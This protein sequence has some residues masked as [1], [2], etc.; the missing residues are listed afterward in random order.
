M[1]AAL[2]LCM[3]GW[4]ITRM[5]GA[6]SVLVWQASCV[7]GAWM[8]LFAAAMFL[9]V[10]AEGDREDSVVAAWLVRAG[11]VQCVLAWG[12]GINDWLRGPPGEAPAWNTDLGG[13][14]VL[15]S[16]VFPFVT[17]LVLLSWLGRTAR[18]LRV[19]IERPA[20]PN[21]VQVSV[22]PFRGI[23]RG[24]ARTAEARFPW[25]P[26]FVAAFG[27]AAAFESPAPAYWML[28]AWAPLLAALT[29]R[30]ARAFWPSIATLPW[31]AAV[32]GS[33]CSA[34]GAAS[35]VSL[36]VAWPWVSAAAVALYLAALE[37]LLR[38]RAG[39]STAR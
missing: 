9:Y 5:L 19:S 22:A 28:F 34:E 17:A 8:P 2:V 7:I 33:R 29:A 15:V 30:N 36:A 1:F 6:S 31:I 39:A 4:F 26:A 13:P 24:D 27:S 35:L 23:A 12:V 10:R 37:A 3:N 32:I 21:A 38:M 20:A 18:R 16:F 14:F 25:A 11:A